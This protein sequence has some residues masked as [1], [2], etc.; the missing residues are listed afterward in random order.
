MAAIGV[1]GARNPGRRLAPR[2]LARGPH[3][4]PR[5]WVR[6]TV[7]HAGWLS[8]PGFHRSVGI[9]L[10]CLVG[11]KYLSLRQPNGRPTRKGRSERRMLMKNDAQMLFTAWIESIW[12]IGASVLAGAP[13]G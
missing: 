13:E 3:H 9:G 7:Y 1:P 5:A 2:E 6:G 4:L 8:P 11:L 12:A 10:F